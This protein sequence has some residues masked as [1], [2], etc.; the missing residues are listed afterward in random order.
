M[1]AT[2]QSYCKRL[3]GETSICWNRFWFVPIGRAPLDL[4]RVVSGGIA[5]ILLLT[6]LPDLAFYFGPEGV[7]PVSAIEQL[8]G[9]LHGVS[10]LNYFTSPTEL[11]VLHVVGIV[12]VAMFT[13]GLFT[14]ITSVAALAVML[15]TVHRGPM[16]ASL[17]EPVVTMVMF[18]YCLGPGGPFAWIA[19]KFSGRPIERVSSW[20]TVSLRLIQVHLCLLYATMGLSKLMS[21]TWWGGSGVWWLIARPESRLFDLT[22][23]ATWEIGGTPIG[24]YVINLWSH[25]IVV[26]ELAFALLI[27]NRLLRPLLLGWSLIH[28]IGVAILLGQPILALMMIGANAAFLD[29]EVPQGSP[30]A[31]GLKSRPEPRD[32]KRRA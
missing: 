30:D 23:L 10:Y 13:L 25:A 7:L 14:P 6:L 9:P 4:L 11:M 21:D 29:T 16:L 12:F 2:T 18:Y 27:W 24:I 3:A 8:E 28:W 1:T 22:G 26:F 19:S 31:C 17:V 15:S 5:L 32:S 20:A